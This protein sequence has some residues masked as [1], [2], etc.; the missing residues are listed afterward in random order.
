[1]GTY[2]LWNFDPAP[3]APGSSD[4]LP[5]A[6]TPQDAFSLIGKGSQLLPI[7]NYVLE[8]IA[9]QSKYRVWSFDPQQMTPLQLPVISEGSWPDIDASHEL[10][11]IGEYLL[12][13]VPATRTYR[14]WHFDPQQKNPLAGPVQSG[15]LPPDFDADCVLTSVQNTVQIDLDAAATPGTMDF[16]RDKIEHVVVYMLESRSMDSVLGW[17]YDENSPKLNWVNAEPPFMGT[18]TTY[19]NQGNGKTFNVY[20]FKEGELSTDFDL[21]APV[22]DPFHG[23][24]DSI[25]QQYSDG[26]EGYF[27][28][29][30][31][32]MSGFVENNCSG[33][34]MVTLTPTQLPVLN[35]LA[36]SYAVS[37][38]WFSALPGGTDSNRAIALTGSAFNITTT[39]EGNPQY[40][41]FPDTAR[42]QSIWKV[43]W[44][45]G[46]K[47]WKI[48]WSVEW[49]DYVFTYHLYLKGDIP[50]V[51]ANVKDYVAPIDQFMSEAA[52]GKLPK[53]SFLE[54]AWIAPAGATSYHPGGDLV[55]GECELNK[56]YQAIADGPG[57]D[58]TAFVITFSKGGGLYD[59]VSTPQTINPW[60]QDSNDGFKYDV[61]GPR[62]PTIVISPW[63]N[64]N[65]V[66]RSPSKTTP[67]SATSLPATLL[68]W[69]G[70]P[71]AR[72]G[73]GD[74]MAEAETFEEV[75]QRTTPRTDKPKFKNPYDKSY[76]PQDGE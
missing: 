38:N 49:Y 6:I 74:R 16:M 29:A 11:V 25:Y 37:D 20:K 19:S 54:P 17:L 33:E 14:L 4:P 65:T 43:L 31:P 40:E 45:N 34:V 73:L 57:W 9:T 60:P 75:F 51:D 63:V 67:L 42:R 7:G 1:R 3:N 41:Y 52:T 70:I 24:P 59:H 66:F 8:W 64:E 56:I 72:W 21:T 36:S 62:V 27:K 46:I 47:D 71:R 30:S 55:P 35:G 50:T 13:W 23:T 22:I 53:F 26:Y 61:L 68:E 12:D 5:N 44:N 18:S 28:G 76:P 15:T 39:Y 58:K 10:L 32:D 2:R 48:Y 69:F